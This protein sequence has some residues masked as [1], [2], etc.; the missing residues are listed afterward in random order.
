MFSSEVPERSGVEPS[1]LIVR[2]RR[3]T[4]VVHI[5]KSRL[6]SILLDIQV[7]YRPC[8][9]SAQHH[10]PPPPSLPPLAILRV[11]DR[12]L[13]CHSIRHR[14]VCCT[15]AEAGRQHPHNVFASKQGEHGVV[16]V[17]R[18]AIVRP[19][20]FVMGL[21]QHRMCCPT[22]TGTPICG[23]LGI[24]NSSVTVGGAPVSVKIS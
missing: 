2:S 21:P 8:F 9:N 15:P 12:P 14:T 5:R 13:L 10:R 18:L 20:H 19:L 6:K 3:R 24:G 11:S 22:F 1:P 16:F 7:A 4:D 23:P 17:L